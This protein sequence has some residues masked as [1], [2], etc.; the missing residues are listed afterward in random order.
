MKQSS[1]KKETILSVLKDIRALLKANNSFLA[2]EAIVKPKEPTLMPNEIIVD[3][4]ELTAKQIVDACS[5]TVNGGKLL[6]NG[7]WYENE[8]F[9]TTETTRPGKRIVSLDLKHVGK[10][11]TEINN[12]IS[13]S[14]Q[15]LNF[16]EAVYLL[17]ENEAFR[18]LL[19]YSNNVYYTWT[20]SRGSG[21]ELV[22]VGGFDSRG[23]YVSD[24]KPRSSDSKLGVCFSRSASCFMN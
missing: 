24:W 19:N 16:A 13:G 17:K 12:I 7:G 10:S 9:Y 18:K 8:A 11:W 15:M 2:R 5:N 6:Y 3:F 21:G 1:N 23:A 4:P 14:L 22:L 20:S